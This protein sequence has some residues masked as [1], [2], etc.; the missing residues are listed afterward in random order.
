MAELLLAQLKDKVSLNDLR[1]ELTAN[2][3]RARIEIDRDGVRVNTPIMMKLLFNTARFNG[4][5]AKR[6]IEVTW[7]FGHAGFTEKGWEVNHYFPAVRPD[8]RSQNPLDKEPYRVT[9]T[10]KDTDQVPIPTPTPIALPV[11][12]TEAK[13]EGRGHIAVELQR[14]AVGFFVALVGLFAGAKEK[15]L[16]LD[17]AGAIFAIFLLGFGID[18]AKNLLVQKSS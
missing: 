15:I 14:W 4:V 3:P 18:M 8:P 7:D 11:K 2:P 16:S 17:T 6:R 9:V 12:V 13:S 5:A 1:A 10:F